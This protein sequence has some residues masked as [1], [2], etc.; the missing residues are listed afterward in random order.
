MGQR[1]SDDNN[2]KKKKKKNTERAEQKVNKSN[3]FIGVDDNDDGDGDGKDNARGVYRERGGGEVRQAG[4]DPA[5]AGCLARCPIAK[6]I[7]WQK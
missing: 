6:R 2:R 4:G 1:D 7:K 5:A 3:W